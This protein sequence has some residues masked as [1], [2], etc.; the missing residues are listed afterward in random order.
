MPM[1][2]LLLAAWFALCAATV[3]LGFVATPGIEQLRALNHPEVAIGDD[4]F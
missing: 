3:L 4:R 1:I 2:V